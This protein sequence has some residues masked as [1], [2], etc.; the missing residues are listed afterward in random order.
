MLR[1]RE[2]EF[3]FYGVKK[4]S[5]Y[6]SK[7]NRFGRFY[8]KYNGDFVQIIPPT[9]LNTKLLREN[10]MKKPIFISSK[11]EG[12]KETL[13]ILEISMLMKT[14]KLFHDIFN[15]I[16]DMIHVVE[17]IDNDNQL[18]KVTLECFFSY[19]ENGEFSDELIMGNHYRLNLLEISHTKLSLSIRQPKFVREIDWVDRCWPPKVLDEHEQ[20]YLS[21]LKNS[22]RHSSQTSDNSF[23]SSSPSSSAKLPISSSTLSKPSLLPTPSTKPSLLP[24]PSSLSISPFSKPSILSPPSTLPSSSS[25]SSLLSPP[26]K[27]PTPDDHLTSSYPKVRKFLLMN[28]KNSLKDFHLDMNGASAWYYL[29]SGHIKFIFCQYT[30]TIYRIYKDFLLN[31]EEGKGDFFLKISDNEIQKID[32]NAGDLLIIPGGWIYSM[33]TIETS[34]GFYGYFLHSYNVVRQLKVEDIENKMKIVKNSRYPY[35]ID[36]YWYVLERYVYCLTNVRHLR[37]DMKEEDDRVEKT[38]YNRTVD[39]DGSSEVILDDEKS[40]EVLQRRLKYLM[41]TE[42]LHGFKSILAKTEKSVK[43]I[44]RFIPTASLLLRDGRTIFYF[45]MNIR[46]DRLMRPDEIHDKLLVKKTP[47]LFWDESER[48]TNGFDSEYERRIRENLDDENEMEEIQPCH[49]TNPQLE[50]EHISE[51]NN[52]E[53]EH[54]PMATSPHL[55][56]E[57]EEVAEEDE[58][59]DINLTTSRSVEKMDE[60]ASDDSCESTIESTNLMCGEKSPSPSS[61]SS[62]SGS[63][64]TYDQLQQFVYVTMLMWSKYGR[65]YNQPLPKSYELTFEEQKELYPIAHTK[66]SKEEDEILEKQMIEYT[67]NV[68]KSGEEIIRLKRNNTLTRNNN[69]RKRRRISYVANLS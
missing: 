40:I 25:K 69:E 53:R 56:K 14:E 63:N 8:L 36:I 12:I 57:E 6:H 9:K 18:V 55:E 21:T 28:S 10:G 38:N 44:Q 41:T 58:E 29:V 60:T 64:K 33:L 34:I 66:F 50:E 37:V 62:H 39:D 2:D 31:T 51:E 13:R 23:Q 32:M 43:R 1:L 49:S 45:Q 5:S 3:S 65:Y 48:R 19:L 61:S 20:F 46:Q 4:N 16:C 67:E 15:Q 22:C 27:L 35:S 11:H 17:L 54:S 68:K 42:E 59:G 30:S 24:T 7:V 26:S 52:N 47:I